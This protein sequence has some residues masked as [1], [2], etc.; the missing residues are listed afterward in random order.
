MCPCNALIDPALERVTTLKCDPAGGRKLTFSYVAW[1][2]FITNATPTI[3][4][5]SPDVYSI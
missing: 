4:P 5:F 3:D 2:T 1:G